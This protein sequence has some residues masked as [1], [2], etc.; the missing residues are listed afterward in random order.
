[1][2]YIAAPLHYDPHISVTH[3]AHHRL[4]C[5]Q[6]VIPSHFDST[7]IRRSCHSAY[8]LYS[9]T[10]YMFTHASHPAFTL[11]YSTYRHI[12]FITHPLYKYTTHTHTTAPGLS[13]LLATSHN[14]DQSS[15]TTTRLTHLTL[16]Y[17][18]PQQPY[19]ADTPTAFKHLTSI[20]DAAAL[21][22]SS[23]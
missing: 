12:P 5:F 14:I 9:N 1:M 13:C 18:L 22:S 21:Y 2:A 20:Y 19:N 6:C 11:C 3:H 17:T 7:D 10:T 4:G 23:S 8:T 15:H 16:L